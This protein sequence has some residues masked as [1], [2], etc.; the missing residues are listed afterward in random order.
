MK[1]CVCTDLFFNIHSTIKPTLQLINVHIYIDLIKTGK[2][3]AIGRQEKPK[4]Q[5]ESVIVTLYFA[6]KKKSDG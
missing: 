6:E 5:A 1:L 4:K 2:V 3:A